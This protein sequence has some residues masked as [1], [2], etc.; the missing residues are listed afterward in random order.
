MIYIILV[1]TIISYI[2]NK[3]VYKICEEL[4]KSKFNTIIIYIS[5]I[6]S[7]VLIY[8]KYGITSQSIKYLSLIPF[9]IIISI[10]DY[11]TT[12]IYDITVINGIIMQGILLF[13]STDIKKYL[14]AFIIGII[15]P[16]IIAK[17]TKGLGE[18]DIGLYGLCCFALGKNYSLYLIALSFILA[19]VYC[20]YILLAKSD[21]IRK[22]PFAPFISLATVL[23][24][25]TNFDI[26]NFWFD[27]IN[28]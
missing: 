17:I 9:I 7:M 24:I 5:I 14:L 28:I 8:I 20:V 21:K 23:I 2:C 25:L 15:V 27:I 6:L 18:G 22:I 16:Y 11:H 10:I 19:S 12:Y 1:S 4:N 26:L 3:Q 13:I